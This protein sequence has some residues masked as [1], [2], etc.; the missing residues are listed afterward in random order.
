MP[1]PEVVTKFMHREPVTQEGRWI[2]P[3]IQPESFA[4]DR[5]FRASEGRPYQPP[6]R[7]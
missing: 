7:G 5:N 6:L 3:Y 2:T 1:G 4:F